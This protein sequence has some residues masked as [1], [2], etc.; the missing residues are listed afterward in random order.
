MIFRS[1]ENGDCW[2]WEQTRRIIKSI[3]ELFEAVNIKCFV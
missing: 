3:E 2:V 1:S